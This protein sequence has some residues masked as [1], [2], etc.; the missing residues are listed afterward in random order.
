VNIVSGVQEDAGVMAAIVGAVKRGDA[1]IAHHRLAIDDAGAC[2]ARRARPDV[3]S[4]FAG[5]GHAARN[6]YRLVS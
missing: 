4:A 2:A 1:A 3:A 6:A 5:K